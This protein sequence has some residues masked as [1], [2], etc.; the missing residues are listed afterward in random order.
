MVFSKSDCLYDLSVR[1]SV[2][3]GDTITAVSH[4]SPDF[5]QISHTRY[6][7]QSYSYFILIKVIG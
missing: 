2:F 4:L 1:P 7:Y 5:F 6:L 3:L